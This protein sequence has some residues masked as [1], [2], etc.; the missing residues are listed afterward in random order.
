MCNTR[1]VY[2]TY[3]ENRFSRQ[4]LVAKKFYST[5]SIYSFCLK[6]KF[7]QFSGTLDGRIYSRNRGKE[8]DTEKSLLDLFH[9]ISHT[10]YLQRKNHY[11]LRK[12]IRVSWWHFPSL[13]TGNIQFHVA[14]DHKEL[15]QLLVNVRERSINYIA[16]II[17]PLILCISVKHKAAR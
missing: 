11:F 2:F 15:F 9:H 12:S 5:L 16:L 4:R 7:H 6:K 17:S 8:L 3:V 13:S 1:H 14:V 10:P